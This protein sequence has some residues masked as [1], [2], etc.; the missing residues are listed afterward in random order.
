MTI[1]EYTLPSE[2]ARPRRIA[3]APDGTIYYTDFARRYLGHFDPQAGKLLKGITERA[4]VQPP[5]ASQQ[6]AG[7]GLVQRVRR[8]SQHIIIY[9]INGCHTIWA[10]L[11][12]VSGLPGAPNNA[13]RA[14]APTMMH[15]TLCRFAFDDCHA[16]RGGSFDSPGQFES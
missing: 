6:A 1:R 8:A 7:R 5:T 4:R 14:R 16:S 13:R 10:L 15:P 12:I 2:D 11:G 3:L 9:F